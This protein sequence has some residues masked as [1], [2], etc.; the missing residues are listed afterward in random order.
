MS[1]ELVGAKWQERFGYSP[2]EWVAHLGATQDIGEAI[3]E[4]R[5]RINN[6][7]L[8][9]SEE[10]SLLELLLAIESGP[11]V[12]ASQEA[13]KSPPCVYSSE[14]ESERKVKQKSFD[15]LS[16]KRAHKQ[17]DRRHEKI[18]RRVKQRVRD[19]KHWSVLD[20]ETVFDL[21]K[22]K[23]K[24]KN[25]PT[26]TGHFPLTRQRSRSESSLRD[27]KDESTTSSL[28]ATIPDE[29]TP[30]PTGYSQVINF[31]SLFD[32]LPELTPNM[33]I[34]G[35]QHKRLSNGLHDSEED[36]FVSSVKTIVPSMA[37]DNEILLIQGTF[38]SDDAQKRSSLTIST[39]GS[40]V[41]GDLTPT[42]IPKEKTSA[43][44]E[45]FNL[46]LDLG[47]EL[48]EVA[49]IAGRSPLDD[50]EGEGEGEGYDEKQVEDDEETSSINESES[51]GYHRDFQNLAEST[52]TYILRD[53][54]FASSRTNSMS[55]LNESR[56]SLSPEPT[57]PLEGVNLRPNSGGK[58]KGRRTAQILENDDFDEERLQKMLE[59]V[60][61]SPFH[62]RSPSSPYSDMTQSDP[63]SP[64]HLVPYEV[65]PHN[66]PSTHT[67]SSIDCSS[68]V[69]S[70][71]IF[72]VD[73]PGNW[74][75]HLP[76]LL[77]IIVTRHS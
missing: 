35:V 16:R 9:V 15:S 71:L 47:L 29:S 33:E 5:E 55:S 77:R 69:A 74:L 66:L 18:A 42:E 53:T 28:L 13:A 67:L 49:N 25:T 24:A 54:I 19:H 50:L 43:G 26:G 1:E 6:F 4:C 52:L 56:R 14:E 2:P 76:N 64:T 48:S 10:E 62:S 34:P 46:T 12:L 72:P 32:P 61:D 22:E 70:P 11:A 37:N 8:R 20:L 30:E 45:Q 73:L 7:K 41:S 60:Q 44:K 65:S 59:E 21:E 3:S 36:E 57:T 68:F 17:V 63:S 40:S 75:R 23:R 58:R 39:G 51:S 27:K 38:P 31:D